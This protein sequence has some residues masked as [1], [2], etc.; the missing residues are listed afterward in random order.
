MYELELVS[1]ASNFF[2]INIPGKLQKIIQT[3]GAKNSLEMI[4]QLFFS[5]INSSLFS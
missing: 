3:E 2:L 1:K 4:Q 5:P